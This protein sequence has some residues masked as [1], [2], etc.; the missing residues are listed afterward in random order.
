MR[1]KK[2]AKCEEVKAA[3]EYYKDKGSK[4]GLSSHCIQCQLKRKNPTWH[5]T[6]QK[7]C[8]K[9]ENMK[10]ITEFKIGARTCIECYG[11][12]KVKQSDIIIDTERIKAIMK[13][14]VNPKA[15]HYY[16]MDKTPMKKEQELGE[17]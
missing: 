16:Y 10:N 15:T 7:T 17:L 6:A 11:V 14:P 13:V 8:R 4:S 3:D 12:R 2:C 1:G 9:C 5:I